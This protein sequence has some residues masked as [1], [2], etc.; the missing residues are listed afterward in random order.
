[1]A[2]KSHLYSLGVFLAEYIMRTEMPSLSHNAWTRKVIQ[3]TW[4]EAQ[5][6]KRLSDDWHS[7]VSAEKYSNLKPGMSNVERYRVEQDAYKKFEKEWNESM[8]YRY[9]LKEK[10]LP[11]TIKFMVNYIDFSDEKANKKIMEGFIS[12]MWNS[13]F[14]EYSLNEEDITFENVTRTYG[15]NDEH[16][17][18]YTFVT[19]KLGLEAPASYTGED[20]IEI[21]TPQKEIR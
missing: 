19:M 6:E 9:M 17:S 5:E 2:K 21:K 20:W 10:Y 16:S 14:C 18:T 15:E 8:K 3:V 1:M 4:G 7:K 11:H 12:S 13:D